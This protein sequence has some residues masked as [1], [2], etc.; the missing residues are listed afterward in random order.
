MVM[1]EFEFDFDEEE[2]D[3]YT[4]LA[5]GSRKLLN[6]ITKD[7]KRKYALVI[8]N[9]EEGTDTGSRVFSSGLARLVFDYGP[10]KGICD[11]RIHGF[12]SNSVELIVAAYTAMKRKGDEKKV[13]FISSLWEMDTLKDSRK[14]YR[15]STLTEIN[16]LVHSE[17]A[18]LRYL[19]Y[20]KFGYSPQDTEE[21]KSKVFLMKS[22]II[23][24]NGE[25]ALP[26]SY[27]LTFNGSP[28]NLV[29]G[30]G[31]LNEI[32]DVLKFSGA[33]IKM[34][35]KDKA[36]EK[37]LSEDRILRAESGGLVSILTSDCI[38]IWKF[39]VYQWNEVVKALRNEYEKYTKYLDK[40][41]CI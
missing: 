20:L 15:E 34:N 37:K 6:S 8:G 7:K 18:A 30:L 1:D 28:K 3:P 38:P 25:L 31:T 32:Y 26:L 35:L 41:V 40:M 4:L 27:R 5:D 13:R 33:I 39:S 14:V 23:V 22:E 12:C 2:V 16:T 17:A 21:T 19:E 9:P 11:F 10:K 36:Y 24:S 29:L